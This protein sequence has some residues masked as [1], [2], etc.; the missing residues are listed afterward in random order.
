[1]GDSAVSDILPT[2]PDSEPVADVATARLFVAVL[3]CEAL[4]ILALW[5][6]GRY[7]S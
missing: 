7:F 2:M 1:V 6:F 4:T 5:A 3:V